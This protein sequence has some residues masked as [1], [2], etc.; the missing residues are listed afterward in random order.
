MTQGNGSDD[1]YL[2]DDRIA[3]KALVKMKEDGTD[4]EL[5]E[6]ITGLF[7]LP[8]PPSSDSVI[9]AL[10]TDLIEVVDENS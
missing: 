1:Q 4:P 10:A 8:G 9:S 2:I 3:V 6:R 5:L 7:A